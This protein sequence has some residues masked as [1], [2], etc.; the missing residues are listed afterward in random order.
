MM[1]FFF[2]SSLNCFFNAMLREWSGW[3]Y[4]PAQPQADTDHQQG[5]LYPSGWFDISAAEGV[6]SVPCRQY[7]STGRHQ[8]LAPCLLTDN[9]GEVHTLQFEQA[10]EWAMLN[11]SVA[12]DLPATTVIEFISRVR[13][14]NRNLKHAI[15][16]RGDE[17]DALFQSPLNFSQAETALFT[18]H[19]IHPCPKARDNFSEQDTLAYAPEYNGKFALQ[20]YLVRKDRL[21]L[22][23]SEGHAYNELV[24]DL[25][26][27][28]K[29]MQYWA[30]QLGENQALFPCH[31]FQ[32]QVWQSTPRIRDMIE[33][34]S[35]VYLGQGSQHWSATSSVRAIYSSQAPWM[36]K[37][38]LTVKLTNSIRHLQ[39][40]ELVRGAELFR[41]LNTSKAREY[42]D[43]FPCFNILMEP[44][45]AA[46]CG[47]DGSLYEES[48][49][50]W[51]QNPF[52]ERFDRNTE[53]LAT[54]LQDDPR[55]G[56]SRLE[57][58]L[59]LLPQSYQEVAVEWFQ[60]YLEVA[61]KPLLVGQADY[62]LLFGAHQQNIVLTL[63]DL[64]YPVKMYFRDC[65]GTGYTHLA[66]ELYGHEIADMAKDSGNVIEDEVAIQLFSYYL[67]VNATFNVISSLCGDGALE[68][69]LLIRHLGEFLVAVK[70]DGINDHQCIDYLL[71]SPELTAKCNFYL[72]LRKTNENTNSDYL[73]TYHQMPNPLLIWSQ[74]KSVSEVDLHRNSEISESVTP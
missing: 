44:T 72:A 29:H 21:Y 18:G 5:S 36:L 67:I 74:G 45:A 31:P 14:S 28:D 54:L 70:E 6:L 12:A 11:S 71:Q 17:L 1:S 13:D 56:T 24:Q 26:K 61:V 33:E 51:R 19:S 22:K 34:G 20:W 3:K 60:Q 57:Q 66:H 30:A 42:V 39:P 43:R 62:G 47:E 25:L 59:R 4:R 9:D 32:H 53:V 8:L 16:F 63:N 73:A 65:Q 49:V 37:Y 64:G 69:S 2:D 7:F 10:M 52:I 23:E 41:V 58:R 27:S 50:L 40:A 46:L 55:T 15:E 35:L 38:S 68:E 48:I